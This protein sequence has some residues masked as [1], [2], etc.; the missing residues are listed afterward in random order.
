MSEN[1]YLKRTLLEAL[2]PLEERESGWV[3]QDG[4]VA[5][6]GGEPFIEV[7]YQS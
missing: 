3:A 7:S 6:A 2:E 4:R 1:C 5:E